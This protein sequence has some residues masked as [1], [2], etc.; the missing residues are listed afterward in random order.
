MQ[1]TASKI[2]CHLQEKTSF[3]AY[4]AVA[5]SELQI[6]SLFE[7]NP[8]ESVLN[9]SQEDIKKLANSSLVQFFH[10]HFLHIFFPW[11]VW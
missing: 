11:L 5:E 3:D 7:N 4:Q 8:A 9:L 2:K 6:R 1:N 10:H